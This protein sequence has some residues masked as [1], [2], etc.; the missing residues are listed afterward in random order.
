[1]G[2]FHMPQVWLLKKKKVGKNQATELK[3]LRLLEPQG[4][5]GTQFENHWYKDIQ[6]GL[7][8]QNQVWVLVLRST[9][10]L[11]LH[12]HATRLYLS[13]PVKLDCMRGPER[14]TWGFHILYSYWLKWIKYWNWKRHFNAHLPHCLNSPKEILLTCF[15]NSSGNLKYKTFPSV[16]VEWQLICTWLT[17]YVPPFL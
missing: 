4:F 13:S 14:L 9:C 2:N 17:C 8:R 10:F 6:L 11:A 16:V 1:M 7:G 5:H 15:G 12:V 3:Q